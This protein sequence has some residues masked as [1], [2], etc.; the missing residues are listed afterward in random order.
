MVKWWSREVT[1]WWSDEVMKSWSDEVVKLLICQWLKWWSDGSVNEWSHEIINHWTRNE[2][3]KLGGQEVKKSRSKEVKN[4]KV[5][6][7]K[8]SRSEEVKKSRGWFIWDKEGNEERMGAIGWVY[9][10]P[11]WKIGDVRYHQRLEIQFKASYSISRIFAAH[12]T[13][14]SNWKSILRYLWILSWLG[15]V[16]PEMV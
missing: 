11:N 12:L 6:K 15:S 13:V 8:R 5:W 14:A 4:Q 1:K 9:L 2:G 10:Y 16:R 7:V 3:I